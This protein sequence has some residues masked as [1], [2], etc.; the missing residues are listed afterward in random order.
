MKKIDVRDYFVAIPTEDGSKIDIPY[1]VKESL[2]SCLFHPEL[3]LGGRDVIERDVIAK[4]IESAEDFVLLE[5]SEY[6]KLFHAFETVR[7]FG[8]AEVE[9]VRRVFEA[10]S[11][12]VVEKV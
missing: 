8:Q 4:K 5:D 3:K 10:E 2:V 1:T 9:L 7:G 12:D 11:I 6:Q